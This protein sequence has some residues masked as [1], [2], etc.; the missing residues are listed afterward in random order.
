MTRGDSN[1]LCRITFTIAICIAII[2]AGVQQAAAEY[3]QISLTTDNSTQSAGS[4]FD[5]S[6]NYDVSDNNNNLSGIGICIHYDSSKL[7]Y[8][9][10]KNLS[11][12]PISSPYNKDE[13]N[14]DDDNNTD[15]LI[16]IAWADLDNDKT[17]GWPNQTLPLKLVDFTFKVKTDF[18]E[19]ETTL[20]VTDI[21]TNANY[22]FRSVS[23][24][25]DVLSSQKIPLEQNWNLFS[26]S[27][28][29]I[30]HIEDD[31]SGINALSGAIPE[32]VDS[33]NDVLSSIEGKYYYLQNE[34]GDLYFSPSSGVT[35]LNTMKYLAAGHGYWIFMNEPGTLEL[36]GPVASNTAS[37]TLKSG[38]R[39]VGCWHSHAQYITEDEPA[40]HLF[41]EN[42]PTL[43]VT[44]GIKQIFT[45]FDGDYQ[46]IQDESANLFNVDPD[47][48]DVINNFVNYIAPGHAYW[49]FFNNDVNFH[50]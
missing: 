26:F 1:I 24:T 17:T 42:T 28:N 37:M 11:V 20:N 5:V 8:V 34:D 12:P 45:D 15:K 47:T 41:P 18:N 50:Y 30:Y 23:T 19:G 44:G 14:D 48:N 7:E 9:T 39:L 10:Y 16:V 36:N 3:Q 40:S 31:I 22:S 27:V 6:V 25:I 4:E 46:I 32:K 2:H 38:W 43:H 49:I 29:K 35:T 13:D 21:S 33:I